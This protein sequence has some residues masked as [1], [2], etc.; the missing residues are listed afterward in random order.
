MEAANGQ[1]STGK[2]WGDVSRSFIAEEYAK[3]GDLREAYSLTRKIKSSEFRMLA[4]SRII[5]AWAF[6]Q[7]PALEQKEAEERTKRYGAAYAEIER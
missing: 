6:Y 3:S 4:L 1:G 2:G 5:K 7:N